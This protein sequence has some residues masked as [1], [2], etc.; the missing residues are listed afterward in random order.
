MTK[1]RFSRLFL[2]AWLNSLSAHNLTAGFKN[3]G[4]Y[5]FNCS[6]IEDT[7]NS[8]VEGNLVKN[9]CNGDKTITTEQQL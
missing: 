4:V 2:Q 7:D 5:S 8:M 9:S 1:Y 3:C 6:A